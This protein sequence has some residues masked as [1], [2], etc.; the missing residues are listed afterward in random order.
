MADNNQTERLLSKK[1]VF[2]CYRSWLLWNLS[3][4]N[5]ERMQGPAIVRMLG[6]VMDKLYPGDRE[7]QKELLER[8]E[9]FFNTE[10]YLGCIV[11]GVV[12]GM[13]E[14][15]ARS[16]G[17][18]GELINGVKTALMGPFAGIG[19]SLYVGTLIPI[20]LSIALGISGES[21]SVAGPI[22]YIIAHL[23]IMIPVTWFMFYRGY[24]MGIDSAQTI[25]AGG[26]KD[27]LTRAINI[28]GLV[29]VGCITAQYV[30]VRTGWVF[31]SGDMVVELNSALNGVFPNMITL[32]LALGT[33]WLM[34]K[35]KQGIGKMFLIFFVFA[36]VA[37]FTKFIA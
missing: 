14:E 4:Q 18:P 15:N 12:L 32:I 8:H 11:P 3:V 5:M 2:R 31:T 24:T 7:K 16:G 10:P 27:R 17:V 26:M 20:L 28:V 13:E 25:L 29:V 22:F 19:D 36:L 35:K 1:D 37:Y 34:A 33:Y 9:P 6:M 21:G 30:N 23:A